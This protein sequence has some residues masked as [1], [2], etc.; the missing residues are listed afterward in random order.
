MDKTLFKSH[1]IEERSQLA[2]IKREIHNTAKT[3]FS[4]SR[5][6]EIDIVVS[7]MLSNI[8]KYATR[9]ELLVRLD[10]EG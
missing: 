1:L 10:S 8:I 2:F 7:E 3:H 9:G 5:T 6:G 4:E